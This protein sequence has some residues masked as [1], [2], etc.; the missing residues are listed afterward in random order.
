[1]D[2][3]E[4]LN[5]DPTKDLKE[6][7][8][9]YAKKL[10]ECSPEKDQEGFQILRKAYEEAIKKAQ[11]SQE[12]NTLSPVDKFMKQFEENYNNYAK[13][14]D[15][16]TWER[17]L[18][19]D[20]CYNIDTSEEVKF[21][22]LE[23]LMEHYN[24]PHEVWKA[25][26][27]YFLWSEIKEE[28][29]KNF[30]EKFI[31]FILYKSE[32]KD[33]FNYKYLLNCADNK[34]DDFI[35]SYHNGRSALDDSDMYNAKLYIDEAKKLCPDHPNL[36]ILIG[37][38]FMENGKVDKAKDLFTQVIED[39]EN[40]F[41]GYLFRGN[42]FLKIGK[43]NEAYNDYK[44]ASS[45]DSEVIE[46]LFNLGKCC[47]SL[48]KY[49]E[50][51]EY[52]TKLREKLPY[53]REV[54]VSL[55]SAYNFFLEELLN[56]AEENSDDLDFQYK[57]AE[58]YFKTNKYEE[59]YEVLKKLQETNKKDSKIY[60]LLCKVLSELDK[61][62]LAYSMILEGL[63]LF[64]EDY[65]LNFYKGYIAKE[66]GK[67]EEAL[68]YYDKAIQ[69]KDDEFIVYNNKAYILNK[70][71]R[72]SEALDCANKA[73]ELNSNNVLP[74]KNKAEA[75]LGLGLYEECLINC[76]KGLELYPYVSD[77]YVIKMKLFSKVNQ[78]ENAL[79]V[80]KE[81]IELGLSDANLECERANIS[82]KKDEYKKALQYCDRALEKDNNNQ[83]AYFLKGLCYYSEGNYKEALY[84]FEQ[85]IEKDKRFIKAY[86][87]K[88]LTL[89]QQDEEEE[90]LKELEKAMNINYN[91]MLDEFYEL[92]GKILSCLGK[93]EDSIAAYKKAIEYKPQNEKKASYYYLLGEELKKLQKYEEA[94]E[95]FDKAID[96]DSVMVDAYISKSDALIE[97]EEYEK[98]MEECDKALEIDTNSAKAYGKKVKALINL[99]KT[100]EAKKLLQKGLE[101]DSE[102]PEMLFFKYQFLVSARKYKKVLE[103]I[104][105]PIN[106]K[107]VKKENYLDKFYALKAWCL[108][109]SKQYEEAVNTYKKAI[110]HN[111]KEAYYYNDLGVALSKLKN[112]EEANKYI[113]KGLELDPNMFFLHRNQVLIFYNLNK[114]D[115]AEKICDRQLELNK[116]KVTKQ[117]EIFMIF[118]IKCL[119]A[120]KQYKKVLDLI[121]EIRK[122]NPDRKKIFRGAKI[123]ALF[124]LHK[125]EIFGGVGFVLLFRLIKII[126]RFM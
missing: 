7:K 46:L 97:L 109:K 65:D 69:I 42:L 102:D 47:M 22:I 43:L 113:E 39:D 82:Y 54:F 53:S 5:I 12:D 49:E 64:P 114:M 3:F 56:K 38:Y 91:S 44:K 36:L 40:S 72:Y 87:Y 66:L 68:S 48:E 61:K 85:S 81:A 84:Y 6:I 117:S 4:V 28:L 13:R 99:G 107:R 16:S 2:C 111:P 17:L 89:Y 95:Y 41:D 59:S 126:L 18:E 120:K 34:Q 98:A 51:I 35:K 76:D 105:N 115:E 52:L 21:R 101:I 74:Y 58:M 10:K 8:R 23:F 20:V 25:F 71:G 45:I 119:K 110:E 67:Y 55:Y 118:K 24:L 125:G 106:S 30:P 121:D 27:T 112:Y 100:Y 31:D 75:L 15:V 32:Q 122:E 88:A 123:G 96:R 93:I 70:L 50:A 108:L 37:R 1:M 94:I 86:Y 77:I 92:K 79:N 90:A 26:N 83:L 80:Y 14:I 9:A 11:E 29:Y 62:E 116:M 19:E 57:L 104:Q 103:E 33:T 60:V 78:Y 124:N 73:L 63:E